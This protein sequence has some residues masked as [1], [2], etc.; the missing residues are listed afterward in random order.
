MQSQDLRLLFAIRPAAGQ[1][2]LNTIRPISER[3]LNSK[4]KSEPLLT[5]PLCLLLQS[6]HFAMN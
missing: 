5:I 1:S 3:P 6:H 4:F 2:L